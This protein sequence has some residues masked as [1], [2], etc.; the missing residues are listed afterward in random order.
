MMVYRHIDLKKYVNINISK[1]FIINTIIIFSYS[2]FLYY[3]RDLLLNIINLIVVVCY[4]YL[5][6]RKFLKSSLDTVIG[7][8]K[9]K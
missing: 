3:Q 5:I 1:G 6:N 8:L 2:I 4:A 7:K 9:R